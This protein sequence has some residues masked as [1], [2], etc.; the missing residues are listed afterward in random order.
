M[1]EWHRAWKA[2][3][4]NT[5]GMFLH[6]VEAACRWGTILGAVAARIER[7]K[8]LART[9]PNDPADKELSVYELRALLVLKRMEARKTETIEDDPTIARAVRWMADLGGYDGRPSTR[10]PG[11]TVIARGMVKV[12]LIAAV[13]EDMERAQK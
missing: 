7:L 5:E 12:E 3:G 6:S 10:P 4:C 11:A 9:R 1:E 8:Q 13:L 2:S